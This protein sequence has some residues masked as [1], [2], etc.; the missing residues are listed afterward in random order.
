MLIEKLHIYGFG[1]HEN[2]EINL[3][4]GINVF[5]GEN[6]AGKS[7]IQ[8]FI[9]HILFGFPQRNAQVLRYEPKSGAKYGGRIQI[10]DD[11]GARVVIERVKG[12]ASGDVTLYFEDGTRAGEKELASLLH[13]YSRADFEAIFS[14]SLLQLQ[15]FEKMTEDELT[16]TLL[17]SGTT[18]MDTLSSVEAQFVKEMGELFKPTG[19][20]PLINQKIEEVREL[21][22][23]WKKLIEEADKY[24]PSMQRLKEIDIELERFSEDEKALSS[25]LQ[26]Y[27]QWKQLHPIKVKEVELIHALETVKNQTFPPDGIRRFEVIKDKETNIKIENEQLI[28]NLKVLINNNE[29]ITV[30]QLEEIRSFLAYETEWHELRAKRIQ[31]EEEHSNTLQS[32]MQQLAL[33]GVDWEK[34][35]THIVEADVSIQ[36]EDKLVSLLKKH[37]QLES[38]LQQE[39]RLLQMKTEDLQQQQARMTDAK[40][41]SRTSSKKNEAQGIG[42]LFIGLIL[43]LGFVFSFLQSNWIIALIAIIICGPVYAGFYFI[44]KTMQKTNDIQAYERLLVKEHQTLQDQVKQLEQAINALEQEKRQIEQGVQ[45]FLTTYHI[46]EQ[47]SPSLLPEL[48]NR[49]RKIQDQQIQLEHMETNLYEVRSRL[50]KLEKQ[51]QELSNIA[52]VEGMLFH[53]LREFYLSEKKRIEESANMDKQKK[54][55]DVRLKE[56]QLLLNAYSENMDLLFHEAKV[57]SE[58]DYYA[59]YHIYEQKLTLEKE[60]VQIELQLGKK[61]IGLEDFDENFEIKCN[62]NLKTL[63]EQR[64]KLVEEKASLSYRST[65]LIEDDEQS[66]KLQHLEQKK[67]ELQ[68]LVKK[69][70]A[71]KAVVEAIKQIMSQLKEEKL[72]EVLE[73]AQSYFHTLTGKAYEQLE[74]TPEGN[75]EAIKKTGQRFKIAE[76]SQ[77]TKE[78]AYISLRLALA[79]SLKNKAPFPI[80]MDDPFVHFDR[81]RLQQ[82]VQL[83]TELQEQHQLLYFT[84]HEN[85]QYVWKDAHIVQVET[86]LNEKGGIVQ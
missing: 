1:K 12:K 84:C 40:R 11:H 59:A 75:F 62:E 71:F 86:L 41:T 52:L 4:D 21:E 8:Q 85:M 82:M 9:L 10:L 6:E 54:E 44:Q 23:E 69:W 76:L 72:P 14:F 70:A 15:G 34:S 37:E 39:S 83:M 30:Q 81:F 57:E 58:N 79:V 53:Q 66:E 7:T 5:F 65:K 80:I 61:K 18:G 60:L 24:E 47:L 73:S 55:I 67:A 77:A 26:Q 17:S 78:Q 45:I 49:F 74:L 29:T 36:Q 22:V 56:N 13:S 48:F 63:Q 50:Q 2:V 31:I 68:Q 20:K 19:K 25:Q 16:R 28:G 43:I 35:L 3:I 64:N 33:V 51:A 42:F 46:S 27:M 38:E 32:Q